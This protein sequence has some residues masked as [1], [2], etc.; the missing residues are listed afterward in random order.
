MPYSQVASAIASTK[1]RQILD[2]GCAKE[3][4]KTK[5]KTI[6][7]FIDI[8]AGPHTEFHTR[9]AFIFNS[10]YVCFTYGLALPILFP[11]TLLSMINMYISERY[12]FAY[13]YRK[14]PLYGPAMQN[15]ALRIL[16]YAP[17][18][19]IFFGYW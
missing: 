18:F 6:P 17:Y 12:L 3:I 13:Y 4:T 14:P 5:A 9:Y 15:G 16:Y 8:H 10:I 2:I 11:I 7:Q 19:M 1:L